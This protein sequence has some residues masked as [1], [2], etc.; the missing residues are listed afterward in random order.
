MTARRA[1]FCTVCR[2]EGRIENARGEV[3]ACP[4]CARRA[5][6]E[7]RV[8]KGLPGRVPGTLHLNPTPP[9]RGGSTSQIQRKAA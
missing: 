1:V 5:E 4:L 9:R 8:A 2:N 7:W 6:D 3:D